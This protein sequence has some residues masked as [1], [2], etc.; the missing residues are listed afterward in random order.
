[1]APHFCPAI[2]RFGAVWPGSCTVARRPISCLAINPLSIC[3]DNSRGYFFR[4]VMRLFLPGPSSG[5]KESLPCILARIWQQSS[6]F[7]LRSLDNNKLACCFLPSS[8]GKPVRLFQGCIIEFGYIGEHATPIYPELANC[9]WTIDRNRKR[10]Q[11]C[12]FSMECS[13]LFS[14]AY[15]QK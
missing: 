13:W 15:K 6:W 7:C 9:A 5:C 2:P 10:V 1:M 8:I 11:S 12:S 3:Q 4:M 14:L